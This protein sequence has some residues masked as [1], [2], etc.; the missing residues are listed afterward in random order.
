MRTQS[1][2]AAGSLRPEAARH[3]VSHAQDHEEGRR[4]YVLVDRGPMKGPD[5]LDALQDRLVRAPEDE[6][7]RDDEADFR[8]E[9][10]VHGVPTSAIF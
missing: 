2:A 4:I 6:S 5:A 9:E 3:D 10:R 8:S 7:E 1:P